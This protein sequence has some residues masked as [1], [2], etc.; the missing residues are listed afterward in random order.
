MLYFTQ[1]TGEEPGSVIAVGPQADGFAQS[2]V[3]F[4]TIQR[5]NGRRG[6]GQFGLRVKYLH[7]R[8]EDA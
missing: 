6:R 7:G 8:T 1:V 4:G 3:Q 5:G 2:G